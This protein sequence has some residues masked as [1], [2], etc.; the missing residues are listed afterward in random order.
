MGKV[1]AKAAIIISSGNKRETNDNISVL[2][3]E[4]SNQWS[5]SIQPRYRHSTIGEFFA[6]AVMY[7]RVLFTTKHRCESKTAVSTSNLDRSPDNL[8]GQ[9]E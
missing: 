3:I 7:Y 4:A 9:I 2:L 6:L 1:V 8:K 5:T